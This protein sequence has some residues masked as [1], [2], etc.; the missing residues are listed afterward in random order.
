MKKR[1][2]FNPTTLRWRKYYPHCAGLLGDLF[3]HKLHPHMLATAPL[4]SDPRRLRRQQESRHD[5]KSAGAKKTAMRDAEIVQLD[6]E[7]Q[8]HGD[9]HHQQHG[10]R[11]RHAGIDRGQGELTWA[12]TRSSWPEKASRI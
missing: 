5:L 4:S 7:F 3:P 10:Q 9:A 8:R 1:V 2:S 6:A 12:V 11:D